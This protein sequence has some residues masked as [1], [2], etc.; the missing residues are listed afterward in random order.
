LVD[1]LLDRAFLLDESYRHIAEND[2]DLQPWRSWSDGP[3]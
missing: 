3:R 2:E 1:D